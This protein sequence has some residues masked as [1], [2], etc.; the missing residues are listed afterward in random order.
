LIDILKIYGLDAPGVFRF[1]NKMQADRISS[2]DFLAGLKKLIPDIF[3]LISEEEL[4][5]IIPNPLNQK[6]V[7]LMVDSNN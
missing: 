1:S 6:I 2:Q 7:S 5:I 3:S 4:T